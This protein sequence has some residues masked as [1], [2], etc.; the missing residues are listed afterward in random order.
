MTT[1]RG[2][3]LCLPLALL[4]R[5]S[6]GMTRCKERHREQ[7][8]AQ[9]AHSLEQAVQRGLIDHRA[10]QER[11][12]IVFQRDGQAREP[13]RPAATRWPLTLIW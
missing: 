8:Q 13:V 10:G 9:I 3:P 11:V 2:L 5:Y 12:A 6:I 7:G 1:L 4:A